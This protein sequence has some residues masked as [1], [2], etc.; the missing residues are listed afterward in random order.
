MGTLLTPSNA[1]IATLL[2]AQAG[3]ATDKFMTPERVKD[4]IEALSTFT[5]EYVSPEQAGIDA[6]LYTLAHGLGVVPKLWVVTY[7]IDSD[8]LGYTNGNEALVMYGSSTASSISST[9]VTTEVDDT[10]LYVQVGSAGF[11]IH[12]KD[13]SNGNFAA[14]SGNN[15][16]LI[17]R[18]WA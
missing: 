18:A 14:E 9:G 8:H 13:A 4:A 5:Q 3:T 2:E 16:D 17:V 1:E 10:N 7:K 11:G 6:A 15:F 12:R